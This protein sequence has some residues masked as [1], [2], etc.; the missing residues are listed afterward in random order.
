MPIQTAADSIS[1]SVGSPF[2]FKNRI[3]NGDM[4]IDQRKAGTSL[5]VNGN[6]Y[7]LDRWNGISYVSSSF[8]QKFTVARN[9]GSVTP[10]SGFT[11][12]LGITVST[13]YTS[14]ASGDFF[15]MVQFVEGYNIAD[16]DWGK[17]TAKSVTLSFWV[18]GS[19]V[20]NYS[21]ALRNSDANRAYATTYTINVANTWE[22]KTITIPG[23]TTGSWLTDNNRGVEL[24]FDLG[25]HSSY[26]TSSP[27]TWNTAG[28]IRV[29]GTVRLLDTQG[30]NLYITGV[31]LEKGTQ[32]TAFDW[33]PIST[34]LQLCQR[35][36]ENNY[37]LGVAVS[38][39]ASYF[40]YTNVTSYTSSAS[41][42]QWIDFK[43]TKRVTPTVTPYRTNIVASNDNSWAL[44]NGSS[45]YNSSTATSCP[46]THHGFYG[47]VTGS[48][49]ALVQS[50]ICIGA[51]VASAEL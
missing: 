5:L 36:Y 3:I 24:N 17:T 12:Y 15:N 35:Y 8:T 21:V 31:Q 26:E 51:W 44:Y 40:W 45:W 16:F 1:N 6:E 30:A 33:R 47:E 50:Y 14:W 11:N 48:G 49:M 25:R 29:A 10:P 13:A 28:S 32:A 9:L 18:R 27:N 46:A 7:T 19:V 37:P 41:R 22:Y 42:S 39:S 20:G 2:G 4:R 38:A 23:E 34:E 43:V